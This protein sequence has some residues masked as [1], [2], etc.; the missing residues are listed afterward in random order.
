M[1]VVSQTEEMVDSPVEEEEEGGDS[2]I[3]G[4]IDSL[5]VMVVAAVGVE[6]VVEIT[7]GDGETFCI[8]LPELAT[9]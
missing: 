2:L 6:E 3:G 1:V 5:E 7:I 8:S 9:G 4:M